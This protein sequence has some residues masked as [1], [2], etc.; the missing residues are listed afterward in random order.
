MARL[1]GIPTAEVQVRAAQDLNDLYGIAQEA[2]L[3]AARHAS[4]R[5]ASVTLTS[6]RQ[7]LALLI[8]DDGAGFD[9]AAATSGLGIDSMRFRAAQVGAS[10]EIDSV[11]GK[12]TSVHVL[13]GVI[14][15]KD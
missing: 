14:P 5:L 2:L 15:D 4:S 3:N 7:H 11:Q 13:L 9:P 10:L 12:G 6:S 8:E 1:L